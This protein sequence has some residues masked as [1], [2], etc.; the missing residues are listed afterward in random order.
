MVFAALV[1]AYIIHGFH[2]NSSGPFDCCGETKLDDEGL[3]SNATVPMNV[4]QLALQRQ[5]K[6][7]QQRELDAQREKLEA[8]R[9]LSAIIRNSTVPPP[10]LSPNQFSSR[11]TMK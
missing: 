5:L 4:Q 2:T 7:A 1:L 3:F 9:R 6:Q 11:P 8:A 10:P